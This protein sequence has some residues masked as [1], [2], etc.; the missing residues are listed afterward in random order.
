MNVDDLLAR[1]AVATAGWRPVSADATT[2]IHGRLVRLAQSTDRSPRARDGLRRLLLAEIDQA[3]EALI[4]VATTC[5]QVLYDTRCVYVFE[6]VDSS[7]N[8]TV[9]RFGIDEIQPTSSALTVFQ[10]A[11]SLR[12]RV[13]ARD[14]SRVV[15]M[16]ALQAELTTSEASMH[17]SVLAGESDWEVARLRNDVARVQDN[18]RQLRTKLQSPA[19]KWLDSDESRVSSLVWSTWSLPVAL[20]PMA[21]DT[22][23]LVASEFFERLSLAM[24]R[25]LPVDIAIPAE[26]FREIDRAW[27]I[28]EDCGSAYGVVAAWLRCMAATDDSMRC[29]ICYR[30]LGPG[31]RRYCS[32]HTRTSKKRQNSRDLHVSILYKQTTQAFLKSAPNILREASAGI[33]SPN[34]VPSMF[35]AALE[36]AVPEPLALPA[37][38]LAAMLRSLLPV[39]EPSLHDLA[40]HHF[41]RLLSLARTPFDHVP[42]G[43]FLERSNNSRQRHAASKWLSLEVFVETW[44]CSNVAVPWADHLTIGQGLDADHPIRSSRTVLPSKLVLDLTFMR[45]WELVAKLFEEYAYLNSDSAVAMRGHPGGALGRPPSLATIGAILGASSEAIRETLRHMSEAGEVTP[46]RRRVLPTGVLRVQQMLSR[47][48]EGNSGA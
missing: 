22:E 11:R 4:N 29:A 39:L 3:T 18:V 9:E 33:A 46:R 38:T 2:G 8:V 27:S 47:K 25:P 5:V 6:T 44:F 48:A 31:M 13:S 17:A 28:Y 12:Q 45:C 30:H 20:G 32:T 16:L 41:D 40:R 7:E 42:S 15:N 1:V 23:L 36:C 24:Y 14:Q 26:Q 21:S 43:D 37:A 34:D 35:R 19:L 10:V